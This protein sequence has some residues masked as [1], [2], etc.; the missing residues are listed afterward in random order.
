[1][2]TGVDSIRLRIWRVC[3]CECVRKQGWLFDSWD[4]RFCLTASAH[5][6][7]Q[8]ISAQW[9]TKWNAATEAGKSNIIIAGRWIKFGKK[10]KKSVILHWAAVEKFIVWT[11]V[12]SQLVDSLPVVCCSASAL[13]KS[14]C[15]GIG[16]SAVRENHGIEGSQILGCGLSSEVEEEGV[17]FGCENRKYVGNTKET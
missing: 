11:S 10:K 2:V 13:H 4:N 14:Q 1:M 7:K 15:Q 17:R 12:A 8:I 6:S 16:A 3:V 5:E 9:R